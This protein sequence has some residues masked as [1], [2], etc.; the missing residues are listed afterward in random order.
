MTHFVFKMFSVHYPTN[1]QISKWGLH[2]Q[3][4]SNSGFV[5]SVILNVC[6]SLQVV[7]S[8]LWHWWL[9]VRKSIWPVK[10]W[11]LGTT[12][13]VISLECG[14]N[15]LQMVQLMPLPPIISCFSKIRMVYLSGA[16]LPRLS[17]KNAVKCMCMCK[18]L[19]ILCFQIYSVTLSATAVEDKWEDCQNCSVLY[20]TVSQKNVLTLKRYSSKL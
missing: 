2:S 3:M 9:G 15:D 18:P 16:G 13:M 10:N 11:V 17:W 1:R 12:G 6:Y 19:W 7:P 8:V 20:Y 4:Q 5:S 14:A